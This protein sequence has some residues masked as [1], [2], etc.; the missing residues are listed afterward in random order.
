MI[1]EVTRLWDRWLKG[2][3]GVE[4]H[5]PLLQ[6]LTPEGTEDPL[7]QM[8]RIYNDIEDE[9]VADSLDPPETP[10][11][12]LFAESGAEITQAQR[13]GRLVTHSLVMTIAYITRDWPPLRAS[14]EGGYVLQAVIRSLV[15]YNSEGKSLNYRKL[16]GIKV[17]SINEL[18]QERVAANLGQ[19]QLWGFVIAEV[20]VIRS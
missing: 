7:P 18:T 17:L 12:V 16:N 1:V 2:P 11:L 20:S 8:P 14:I 3:L 13:T 9:S 5:L 4:Y 15:D 19:S 10:A 6:R